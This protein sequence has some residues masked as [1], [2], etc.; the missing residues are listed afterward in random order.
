MRPLQDRKR[1]RIDLRKGP[2]EALDTDEDADPYWDEWVWF[3]GF[4][5][6][7]RRA[8]ALVWKMAEKLKGISHG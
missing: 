4:P 3:N 6:A 2:V 7:L 1:A 5:E 8:R